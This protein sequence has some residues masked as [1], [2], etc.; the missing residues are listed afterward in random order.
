MSFLLSIVVPCFNE[1]DRLRDSLPVLKEYLLKQDFTWEVIFV[2]DGGS[3]DTAR[4]PFEF[5][6]ESQVRTI[7]YE[8][9][10]GKGYAVKRGVLA[11]R[12]E[13]ILLSDADF[14]T[15][16]QEWERLH[17]CLQAGDQVVIGS[18]SL[19]DSNVV[20]HQTWVREL[21]GKIFN[22]LIRIIVL[23]GFIDTQCG[24]KLFRREVGVPIFEKMTV[25]RFCFDVEFLFIARKRG[26]KIR[27]LPV[28]WHD[29]LYS[30]VQMVRDSSRM[31]I[32]AFRIRF[33][34][35]D[36]CYEPDLNPP[37]GLDS[38]TPPSQ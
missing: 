2:D 28:E 33:N 35:W 20:V 10:R 27:E 1:A 8:N 9:N 38:E 13:I 25:D 34:D 4:V 26:L 30:R 16:I 12:G 36:G 17:A 21:M 32:D 29:V 22:K 3:D 24:F 5:F 18:R 7:R 31:L 23:R 6:D 11:A 37:P 19:P 15:P 14:S